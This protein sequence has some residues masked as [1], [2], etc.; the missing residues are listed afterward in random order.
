[1]CPRGDRDTNRGVSSLTKKVYEMAQIQGFPSV[2]E[3][4]HST[5]SVAAHAVHPVIR[6]IQSTLTFVQG[7]CLSRISRKA[8]NEAGY[9]FE[10]MACIQYI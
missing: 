4:W 7:L 10:P 6:G 5:V 1:M 8:V 3:W 9:R 2:M